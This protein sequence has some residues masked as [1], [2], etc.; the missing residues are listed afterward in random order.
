MYTIRTLL[1]S[2]AVAAVVG[3][4]ALGG[5]YAQTTAPAAAPAQTAA[6]MA[7][8]QAA[9]Q[10]GHRIG[11]VLPRLSCNANAA[12]Q[13]ETKLTRAA[14]GLALT[15]EQQPLFDAYKTA[16][17]IDA[18]RVLG[19]AEKGNEPKYPPNRIEATRVVSV[20]SARA[21]ISSMSLI[22]ATRSE[23]SPAAGPF[24]GLDARHR[25]AT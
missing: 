2:T 20:C 21:S 6:P 16:V 13:L 8:A 5:A 19:K 25:A 9:P 12:G 22:R 23:P 15:A 7:P 11:G 4:S 1:L 18:V 3:A 10:G 24:C 17:R 14:T